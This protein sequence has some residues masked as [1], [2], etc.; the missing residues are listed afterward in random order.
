M[1]T[2]MRPLISAWSAAACCRLGW[3]K[4]ASAR[5]GKPAPVKA[6]ASRRTP[7]R[8]IL[9]LLAV[10]STCAILNA[11]LPS[12]LDTLLKRIFD[13]EDFKAK[14]FGPAR[15]MEGGA[16]Y[17]TVEASAATKDAKDIV[18][19]EAATGTRTVLVAAA[20]LQPQG[21]TKPLAIDDYS[22]SKG[23]KQLLLFTNSQKVWRQ[24][25]RGDYWVLNLATGRLRQL[26]GTAPVASLMFA[27]FS[28]DGT[29]VAYVRQ[30]NIYVEDVSS[31]KI[32]QLTSTGSDTIINGTADWVYE[33]ELDIRD[34]FRWS[35]DGTKIAY[36]CF[37]QSSVNKFTLINDTD[38]LYPVLTLIPY[39]KAGT[40]NSAV[41]V[42][43][44]P[45]AGGPA[46]WIRNPGDARNNYIARMDWA[47]DSE[48]VLQQ[49]NRLQNTN[50]VLLADVGNGVT[51]R[52]LRDEDKAW[53]D[54][55]DDFRWLA[56]GQDFL[57]VSER[58]GWRR[59]YRVSRDGTQQKVL[60]PGQAEVVRLVHSDEQEDWLYYIAS[61]D[62]AT[63]RYL[64]RARMDGSGQPLRVTSASAP[65][66]HSYV[67]SPNGR[68]AFHTY[69]AY[70]RPPVTD[71]ISLPGHQSVRMLEDN[72][73]LRKAVAPL[74]NPPVEFFHVGVGSGVTLDGWMIKPP[75]FDASKKYPLLIYV[76]G[77]PAGVT[78]TDA[79]GSSRM[80]FHRAMARAGYVVASFD[81][82]GTP[83]PKGRDW[84]K[85]IYG[86]VGVLS[87][88]EQATAVRALLK[89]RSYLDSDR[90]AVWGWSGGGT[91]TLNLMFRSPDLYKVG[92]SVAPVPDQRLYDTIYQERYMGLPQENTEGYKTGSA[93]NFAEGLKGQLL[94]IHGSGDDNVH[95]QGT[96]KLINR[97][98]ELGK[99]F[100]LMVYPNR[101][102]SISEG[103]GTSLHLHS[104]LARYLIE[105]MPPG[106]R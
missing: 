6:A 1:K 99:P 61:P 25:T 47:G 59:A 84:R 90:V 50:D 21:A 57:W 30:N 46:V 49:L 52:V 39:P 74:A 89:Q 96:E 43:V 64:Y 45:A 60:T 68:W 91:N 28:P 7:K 42:G 31:G 26:G 101:S 33:E 73:A 36:W 62:N 54:V 58:D 94:L 20:R 32:T 22:W 95:Y 78:V 56:G 65:G 8:G 63:Q 100:D 98:V 66:T 2:L 103:K 82:R 88:E 24:N 27:K 13:K 83:A 29:R 48:L 76:Y 34:G 37:D 23:G 17:T 19:Y 3:P 79:W 44:V 75:D 102:H 15:W 97:L 67:I 18:R 5:A 11:Q 72:A 38:T 80:M 93:I 85:V 10:L 55:G 81:N 51:R 14:T 35:P 105:H 41:R 4:L 69:S 104:H 71:L 9:L 53:V 86:A 40:T 87:S 12:D 77:E 106:P 92:M 70:E 16:A